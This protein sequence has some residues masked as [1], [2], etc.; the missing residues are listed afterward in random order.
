MN[1][2]GSNQLVNLFKCD[3][4]VCQRLLDTTY[5]QTRPLFGYNLKFV[6]TLGK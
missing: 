3:T 5:L 1:L 4:L 2:V 6:L